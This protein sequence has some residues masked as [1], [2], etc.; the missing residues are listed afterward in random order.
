MSEPP[1]TPDVE[2]FRYRD[3]VEHMQAGFYLYHLEDRDDDRTLRLIGC[4]P[5][6]ARITRVPAAEVLGR[7]L[8][9][10]FPRLRAVGIPQAYA[11][12]VRTGRP[13]TS[14]QLPYGDRRVVQAAFIVR[15][16]P[17][18]HDCVG[19]LFEDATANFRAQDELRR[20]E[21]R[22]RALV[23]ALPD[24]LYRV[25]PDGAVVDARLGAEGP[26]ALAAHIAERVT[27]PLTSG[28]VRVFEYRDG[29]ADFEVRLLRG[30][31]D[32]LLAIV[33]DI[34]ERKSGD[35]RKDEFISIVSHEL[36][37]PLTSIHGALGLMEG[38]VFGDVP[39]AMAELVKVARSNTDRLVR[40]INDMLDLDKM[41]AGRIDLELVPLDAG[42]LVDAALEG[43]RGAAASAGVRLRR[44]T[45]RAGSVLGDRDRLLQV[46]TNLLSNAVRFSPPQ[47]C[48][49]VTVRAEAGRVRF[50]VQDE[51]PGIPPDRVD[52]LFRKFAT[53]SGTDGR[54]RGGTGLGLA[55]SKPLVEQHGGTIGLLP[56]DRGACF[57]FDLP[58]VPA[59]PARQDDLFADLRVAYAAAL[60]GQVEQLTALLA[61]L[62]DTPGARNDALSLSHRLH[63]TAGTYGFGAAS[64]AAA[65]IERALRGESD[66]GD[67]V[68]A[69]AELRRAAGLG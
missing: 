43:M 66:A 1:R 23:N 50:A 47:A 55:I 51:G 31:E 68:D 44:V 25:E 64:E 10:N 15:A 53:V 37:T 20:S 39:P 58:T 13:W 46:L 40:L 49:T 42:D 19:V 3:I 14:D 32:E 16:F 69:L 17:L 63:G 2:A 59:P 41:E 56:C 26:A 9:E 35:R 57:Y 34:T 36:R 5:A 67:L 12:V 6:S 52:H 28:E 65:R 60:P 21:A 4:N 24:T 11:E 45:E 18:P 29:D 22:H 48:V 62:P 61:G 38:G 27:P 8:D 54:R 33:R 30:G 7:T